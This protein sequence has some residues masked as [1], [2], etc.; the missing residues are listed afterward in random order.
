MVYLL[1]GQV[2]TVLIELSHCGGSARQAKQARQ[3]RQTRQARR[4]IS[5]RV[6]NQKW[7]RVRLF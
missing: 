2:V 3:A 7:L 6:A 1:I 4:V 5:P